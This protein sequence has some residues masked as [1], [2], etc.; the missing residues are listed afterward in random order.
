MLAIALRWSGSSTAPEA[1]A[2]QANPELEAVIHRA[3]GVEQPGAPKV[4]DE[5][6]SGRLQITVVDAVSKEPTFCRI[7]VV[8]PDGNYYEPHD[9]PLAPWSLSRLGNRVSKGPFRYFGWFFYSSGRSEVRVPPGKVRVEVWKG[10]EYRPEI[11]TAECVAGK[12][13]ELQI[14]L[15]RKADMAS[16]GW[17][18]GDT[19]IHLDRKNDTDDARA[20]DLAAAEDIRFAH[21]LCMNDPKTYQPLMEQQIWHQL[22]G[23]GRSSERKRSTYQ[24]ASGQEYRCNTYGHICLLGG[25]R[26]VEADGLKTNPNDWPPFGVVAEELHGVGGF[27]FHAHGGY[28]K[29]IYADLAQRATDGVELLQFAEYRDFGLEG[30]Y[31]VLNAGFRFPA[32]GGSDYPYCRVLGDCRTYVQLTGTADFDAWNR[33]AAAGRSFF[34]TGPLV[35]LSVDGKLPGD[36]LARPKGTHRLRVQVRVQSPAC[37]LAELQLI[38]AGQIR[39]TEIVTQVPIDDPLIWVTEL[40]VDSS[41][42]IAVRAFAKSA[43]GREDAEAHTNPVYVN[44]NGAPVRRRDSVEWLLKKLDERTAVHAARQ[45][46]QRPRLMEYFAASRKALQRLLED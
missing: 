4:A 25:S 31:H 11:A 6:G 10:I 44:V 24:I 37:N 19:H 28:G 22:Q 43:N 2:Q 26:L 3:P 38:E 45:F 36:M 29:E 16:H 18:S 12:T 20:L 46:E 9:N 34:T 30:W 40:E 8:G 32:V 27:A 15:E 14:R 23:M 39:Q 1:M 13:A 35:E 7:N 21:I 41:T 42:W 33:G 5:N 17:Y